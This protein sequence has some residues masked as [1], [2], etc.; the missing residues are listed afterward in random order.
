MTNASPLHRPGSQKKFD[1]ATLNKLLLTLAVAVNF[2]GLF[3]TILGPDGTLYASIAKTM[4]LKN[5][6]IELF[7]NGADWLDK[8]HFPFWI[9]A[10]SFKL[11]GIHDWSYRLP[12]ILFLLIGVM[13][14]WKF[15]MRIYQDKMIANWSV[16]I[17]LTAEH[18]ILS[19][20][21][22]R[23]E[24]YLTTTIIASVYHFQKAYTLKNS[25]QLFA[26][27]LFAAFAIM[28]KGIFAFIP[29]GAAI[30][31]HLLL[32]KNWRDLFNVRWL[33]SGILILLLIT[34][35][36][37]SVYYQF[38]LHPEK[39]VY[40]KTGVSG[41]KF[42][43]WD[44]QFGRFFNTG[45][46]K[47]KGDPSF[48]LHTTLWAFLPWSII[49][50]IAIYQRIKNAILK[51]PALEWYTIC[52]SL[53]TFLVFSLSKFQL[54]HYLNIVFP[55]FSILTAQ[56]I[57]GLQNLT[58]VRITQ[59]VILFLLI[60]GVLG[61]HLFFRPGVDNIPVML[62]MTAVLLLIIFLPRLFRA[63]EKELIVGRSVLVMVFVNFY[64][65]GFFYPRLLTYQGGTTAALYINSQYPGYPVVQL[66]PRYNYPLEYYLDEELKTIP[67]INDTT[68]LKKPY[69]LILHN[70]DDSLH[71]IPL[72]SFSIFPISKINIKFLN[73][74]KRKDQLK[75]LNLY[76]V[77]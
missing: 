17:F 41:L 5:N 23:A 9:T 39:I 51:N 6:Y 34:P 2:S 50:Y 66:Q 73:P 53:A 74:E 24:P 1:S 28:T 59:N 77:N 45:P 4:V 22:V 13:Y 26:G 60:T 54:P 38:D 46:I 47:G 7:G 52:G 11:F 58:W 21:D 27:S 68:M 25:W 62:L 8:P 76:L 56:Y 57:R 15:A 20:T 64:L 67:T 44:S 36:L 48:F 69:L 29:I 14:T 31:G 33:I 70:D 61:L 12:A 32:T 75:K 63:S 19:N 18:I 10:I 49:L 55:F 71:R 72:Q 40:G 3:L 35:E 65:N 42:F 37:Y 43:F 16:L 30:G